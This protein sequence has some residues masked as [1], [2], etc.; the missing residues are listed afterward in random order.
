[1][2]TVFL[3]F[4]QFSAKNWR[5]SQTLISGYELGPIEKILTLGAFFLPL[6]TNPLCTYAV[7][8]SFSPIALI[9]A[10]KLHT[11]KWGL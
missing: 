10:G 7:L 5:F 2:V 11:I 4:C 1:M 3:D 9:S 8:E 6:K